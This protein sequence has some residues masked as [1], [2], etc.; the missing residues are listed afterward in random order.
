MLSV[1]R[2]D[3]NKMLR[4]AE[5]GNIVEMFMR[6]LPENTVSKEK[7][8]GFIRSASLRDCRRYHSLA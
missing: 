6:M 2:E 3:R 5:E 4:A 1:N 8:M 7:Y